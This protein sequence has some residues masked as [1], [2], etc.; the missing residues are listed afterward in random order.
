MLRAIVDSPSADV[1]HASLLRRFPWLA[2]DLGRNRRYTLVRSI[3]VN[4]PPAEV[5]PLI[6]D[7]SRLN[8]ALRVPPAHFTEAGGRR[9]G[10]S[11]YFRYDL[12]WE[13][14][15]W[16]WVA[17]HV[18]VCRKIARTGP[19][20]SVVV[21]FA[22][23]PLGPDSTRWTLWYSWEPAGLMG[24]FALPRLNSYLDAGFQK[25]V[26][27][28]ERWA[29]NRDDPDAWPL[30]RRPSKVAP[31]R[32]Q[33]AK[34]AE[35]ALVAAGYD[36]RVVQ[37]VLHHLTHADALDLDRIKP[38]G[39]ADRLDLDRRAT[40]SVC[41]A[42]TEE[43]L[44]RARWDVV[45]PHCRGPRASLSRLDDLEA[46]V[47]CPACDVVFHGTAER[48]ELTFRCHD[49][50][51]HVE[52]RLYCTAEAALK[53]HVRVQLSV[54][55]A[56]SVP[57]PTQPGTYVVRTHNFRINVG[58]RIDDDGAE[59]G[60]VVEGE[61][62]HLRPGG[63]LDLPAGPE[64]WLVEAVWVG[65]Q[66]VTPPDVLSMSEY[67]SVMGDERLRPD[68]AI[69]MGEQALL[70]TDVV[71]STEMYRELGD[72]QAF[73]AVRDH[74]QVVFGIVRLEGGA[75]IKTIGDSV[76]AAFTT[77]EAAA[78]AADRLARADLGAL[79]IRVSLHSGRCIAVAM[80]SGIDYFGSV[81]NE[82]AKLQGAAGAGQVAISEGLAE[83]LGID[84]DRVPYRSGGAER[85]AVVW[86]P[87]A[88][89]A[90]PAPVPRR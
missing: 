17:E 79:R 62:L 38:F 86:T 54:P 12:E 7:T 27:H 34:K 43:G 13:E 50:L 78:R 18:L 85:I 37:A 14:P 71:S 89:G 2:A 72:V 3:D 53:P 65:D 73:H 87:G 70:F 82:A 32:E 68:L 33:R 67:R 30:L 51:R 11:R 77:P 5:W 1:V 35:R 84:G 90:T 81:V 47:E 26:P 44:L 64:R 25:L 20:S 41:L 60:A 29:E 59:F 56:A 83:Q 58:L 39:M 9:T 61:D 69:E 15:P 74:F 10:S 80:N 48:L 63:R 21:V 4:A 36:P 24:R 8:R 40:L 19:A 57:L 42:L 6:A 66:A 52:P 16:D 76:M 45:C 31:E 23:E 28:V 55:E 88:E 22:L 46:D 75:V 49:S